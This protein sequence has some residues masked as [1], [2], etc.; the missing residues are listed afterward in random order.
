[1]S[2]PKLTQLT[3]DIYKVAREQSPDEFVDWV[4]HQIPLF[5]PCFAQ[6]W[7]YLLADPQNDDYQI[8]KPVIF[9]LDAEQLLQDYDVV[10]NLDPLAP[11]TIAKPGHVFYVDANNPEE[12]VDEAFRQFTMKYDFPK[13]L[14][15]AVELP[16]TKN[17]HLFAAWRKQ[18]DHPF[19]NDDSDA[20]RQ[21]LPHIV[22]GL[23]HC[24]EFSIKSQMLGPW[25]RYNSI[26]TFSDNKLVIDIE[27]QFYN[28]VEQKFPNEIDDGLPDAVLKLLDNDCENWLRI[29]DVVFRRH[30]VQS[31]TLIVATQLG[32][33][34]KLSDRELEV[35]KMF[36]DGSDHKMIAVE[37]NRSAA[38]VRNHLRNVYQK[39]G[40]N[41]RSELADILT[42]LA[43]VN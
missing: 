25:S 23:V 43:S 2:I 34:T 19:T 40:I 6:G 38:T 22:Q 36:A 18:S 26:A 15:M 13:C 28:I 27:D 41:S 33:L 20:L 35:S 42:R 9:G 39:L 17:L 37:L 4:F 8:I 16:R 24:R 3:T 31:A 1:M 14:A 11:R 7:T 29:K 21:I 12:N 32:E 10:K 30:N 5:I